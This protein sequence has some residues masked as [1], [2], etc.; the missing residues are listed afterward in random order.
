LHGKAENSVTE[1]KEICSLSRVTFLR[2]TLKSVYMR[3]S[4][5]PKL[6]VK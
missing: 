1:N 2:R 3:S 6:K 5:T 4:R